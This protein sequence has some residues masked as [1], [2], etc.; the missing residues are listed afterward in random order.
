MKKWLLLL[1]FV[2]CSSIIA[3]AQ[4]RQIRG[5]VMDNTGAPLPGASITVSGTKTGTTTNNNGDFVLNVPG[6]GNI[7]LLITSSGY[8]PFTITTDGTTNVEAKLEKDIVVIEDV[9]VVG[10]QTVRRKDLLAS[11]SSVSSKDLKD[12]TINS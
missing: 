8:K 2:L 12:I 11:V 1:M 3:F 4:T 7:T 5:K 10:Y 6:S 9:V